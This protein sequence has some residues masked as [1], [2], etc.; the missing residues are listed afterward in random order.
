MLYY[1]NYYGHDVEVVGKRKDKLKDNTV[2]T[3]DI[4][5]TSYFILNNK[6]YAG[7]EYKDLSEEEKKEAKFGSFMYIWTFSV[8][9]A[10]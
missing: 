5:T 3:F 8:N 9:D 10:V 4:E 1:T 6:I 7:I 2:Y